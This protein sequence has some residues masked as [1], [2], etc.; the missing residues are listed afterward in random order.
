MSNNNYISW[1]KWDENLFLK[2]SPEEDGY[3][4][5]ELGNYLSK[6]KIKNVLEI[7]FGNGNLMGWLIN[8][9][10]V[11]D[12]IEVD[13]TLVSR[14][15]DLNIN[16]FHDM[17]EITTKKYDL[18]IALD[19]LEHIS[20]NDLEFFFHEIKRLL[21]IDGMFIS[22][23][24]NGDSPFAFPTQNGDITHITS[25]GWHKVNYLADISGL[26]M[27][28]YRGERLYAK[29]LAKIFFRLVMSILRTIVSGFLLR[30]FYPGIPK[31]TVSFKYINIVA[32]FKLKK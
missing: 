12:G 5:L 3:F 27:V 22:R 1:K 14:A 26:K 8:K 28:E 6:N 21:N 17:S 4:E 11:V 16:S 20:S 32:V 24:P 7:G 19:V 2:Y 29:S 10:L 15:N 31:G 30:L 18:I 13:S 23:F 25:V 9:G